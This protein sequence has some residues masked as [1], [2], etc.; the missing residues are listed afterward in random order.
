[1]DGVRAAGSSRSLNT[2]RTGG[3]TLNRLDFFPL[4]SPGGNSV[5][6]RAAGLWVLVRVVAAVFTR[7]AGGSAVERSVMT[8]ILVISIAGFLAALD[9]RNHHEHLFLANLGTSRVA[10]VLMCVVP[11]LVGEIVLAM[12]SP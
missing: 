6:L 4:G 9:A 3:H 11:P 1:M 5:A 10:F 7:L 12:V 2:I 8:S